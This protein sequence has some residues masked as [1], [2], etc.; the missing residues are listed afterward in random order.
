MEETSLAGAE[1]ATESKRGGKGAAL[2]QACLDQADGDEVVFVDG[3][4]DAILGLAEV[5][6][7]LR[8]VYDRDAIIRELVRRD[9]MDR[10]GA[11]EFFGYNVADAFIGAP[12]PLFLARI[13]SKRR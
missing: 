13:R 4:D 9:G 2:R 6:G 7:D 12:G 5:D 3:H 1:G 8:V 10:D 11:I